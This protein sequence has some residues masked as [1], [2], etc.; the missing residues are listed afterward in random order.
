MNAKCILLKK[1][2]LFWCFSKGN[3][4]ILLWAAHVYFLGYDSSEQ[5]FSERT[6]Y[7]R[8]KKEKN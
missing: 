2:I 8:M 5:F 3:A 4:F 1:K 7:S 6:F